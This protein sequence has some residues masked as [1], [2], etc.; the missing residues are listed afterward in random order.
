ML[1]KPSP[2]PAN[3][4]LVFAGFI[5][6]EEIARFARKSLTGCHDVPP[7]VDLQIPPPTLPTH[8]LFELFGSITI[9][10]IRPPTLAGPSQLQSAGTRFATIRSSGRLPWPRAIS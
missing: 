7:F 2:V 6:I 3:I 9:D 8:I 1:P 4:V 10:R 5:I